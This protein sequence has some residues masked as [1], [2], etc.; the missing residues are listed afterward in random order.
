MSCKTL[1]GSEEEDINL[2]LYPDCYFHLSEH[3]GLQTLPPLARS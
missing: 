3:A 2:I 1:F